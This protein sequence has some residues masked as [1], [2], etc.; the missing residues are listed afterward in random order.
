MRL[1]TIPHSHPRWL[2]A[3]MLTALVVTV[4]N[5]FGLIRPQPG[6]G[7]FLGGGDAGYDRLF[8]VDDQGERLTVYDATDGRPLRHFDAN[9]AAAV[10]V[11]H[12]GRVF[13]MAGDGTRSGPALR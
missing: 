2:V 7:T 12:D 13:V 1:A 5:G 9:A 8:V 10:L 3:V 4:L 11:R 6:S